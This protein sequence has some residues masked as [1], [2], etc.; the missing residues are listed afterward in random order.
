MTAT[1]SERTTGF[2][3]SLVTTRTWVITTGAVL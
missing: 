1:F 2:T 3:P